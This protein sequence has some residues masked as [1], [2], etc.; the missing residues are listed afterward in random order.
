MGPAVWPSALLR[1]EIPAQ[2]ST[3]PFTQHSFVLPSFGKGVCGR[4]RAGVDLNLKSR[5]LQKKRSPKAEAESGADGFRAVVVKGG[6]ILHRVIELEETT[7]AV[8]SMT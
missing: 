2:A 8:L 4:A 6:A 3:F 1:A 5:C 7:E